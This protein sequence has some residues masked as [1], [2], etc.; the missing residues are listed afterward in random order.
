[1]KCQHLHHLE[2]WFKNHPQ[3]VAKCERL[4]VMASVQKKKNHAAADIKPPNN[5]LQVYLGCENE[6]YG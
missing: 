2:E 5:P 1:M 4:R 6:A 3:C